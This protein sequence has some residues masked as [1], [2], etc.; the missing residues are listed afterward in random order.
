MG[1]LGI[2]ACR[3]TRGIH[4]NTSRTSCSDRCFAS[5]KCHAAD[6]PPALGAATATG[7]P[8]KG[9]GG[10]SRHRQLAC[11]GLPFPPSPS[12]SPSVSCSVHR[13]RHAQAALHPC[14]FRQRVASAR[15]G[16]M[17]HEPLPRP[18]HTTTAWRLAK[19]GWAAS[20]WQDPADGARAHPS[21]KGAER[22]HGRGR[23]W[24]GREKKKKKQKW[25]GNAPEVAAG[26]E[27]ASA[28]A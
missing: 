3:L 22:G 1:F 28:C 19:I 12:P 24:E 20:R 7:K 6:A 25:E 17:C 16:K 18:L 5:C 13:W 27:G 11:Q 21:S 14:L 2:Q 26:G 10:K 8:G 23:A 9:A 15:A 4:F